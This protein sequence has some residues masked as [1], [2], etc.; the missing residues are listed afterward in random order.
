MVNAAMKCVVVV[1]AVVALAAV[2]AAGN[3]E[4]RGLTI[5]GL[6]SPF[7]VGEAEELTMRRFEAWAKDLEREYAHEEEKMSRFAIFKE[8]MEYA[9]KANE[10]RAC[11]PPPGSTRGPRPEERNPL[12]PNS[13]HGICA[14]CDHTVHFIIQEYIYIYTRHDATLSRHHGEGRTAPKEYEREDGED[15]CTDTNRHTTLNFPLS[16]CVSLSLSLCVCVC[17]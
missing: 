4:E 17:M 6:E 3:E 8:N 13:R 14:V 10:V 11:M 15:S 9:T 5:R 1:G 2:V 7:S 16:S 12:S